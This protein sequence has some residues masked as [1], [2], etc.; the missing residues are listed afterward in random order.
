MCKACAQVSKGDLGSPL[1][2]YAV[3]AQNDIVYLVYKLPTVVI[4]RRTDQ[5]S[6]AH[7]ILTGVAASAAKRP[8]TAPMLPSTA[9]SVPPP[10]A[11]QRDPSVGA[12]GLAH[13]S[14]APE[15]AP[16]ALSSYYKHATQQTMHQ[17]ECKHYVHCNDWKHELP[18]RR[19]SVTKCKIGCE[20]CAGAF[21]ESAG[22]PAVVDGAYIRQWIHLRYK[23]CQFKRYMSESDMSVRRLLTHCTSLRKGAPSTSGCFWPAHHLHRCAAIP[24]SLDPGMQM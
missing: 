11:L 3:L 19:V 10:G 23:A 7:E 6:K 4:S 15:G 20:L 13:A 24:S 14:T 17:G 1:T 8:R 2:S 21:R 9:A 22:Q 12:E 16:C 18:R 5:Y